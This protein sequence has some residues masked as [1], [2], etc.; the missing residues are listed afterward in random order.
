MRYI[1]LI[2]LFVSTTIFSI[3]KKA[4]NIIMFKI[5]TS[6][7]FSKDSSKILTTSLESNL[8]E[9]GYGIISNKIQNEALK[10]Q[11][12]QHK[13]DCYDDECLV[14]TG[15]MLAAKKILIIN[16]DKYKNSYFIK[17]KKIDIETA[18]LENTNA[19]SYK[20]TF[21]DYEKV[22][23]MLSKLLN[24][25]FIKKEIIV[26]REK[27]SLY[28]TTE[29]IKD[30]KVEVNNKI[31]GYTPL[32]VSVPDGNYHFKISK[33]NYNLLE[34]DKKIYTDTK[35]K[36][37]LIP[38]KYKFTILTNPKGATVY[39]CYFDRYSKQIR[40]EQKVLGKTPYTTTIDVK[41]RCF[42]FYKF[43]YLLENK[44]IKYE[45]R[46]KVVFNLRK[47]KTYKISFDIGSGYRIEY[48]D[49]SNIYNNR[50]MLGKRNMNIPEGSYNFRFSKTNY[51]TVRQHLVVKSDMK[52]IKVESF[53][54]TLYIGTFEVLTEF[55]KIIGLEDSKNY[56]SF[57]G[58]FNFLTFVS[59]DIK[60]DMFKFG[61]L[62]SFTNDYKTIRLSFINVEVV[63]DNSNLYF[64]INLVSFMGEL[65][66]VV[67]EDNAAWSPLGLKIGY[68][69]DFGKYISLKLYSKLDWMVMTKDKISNNGYRISSGISFEYKFGDTTAVR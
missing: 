15:K 54:E 58:A 41:D 50:W 34:F 23:S 28:I 37:K 26:K 25:M 4:D 49:S 6:F 3:P 57:G 20:G 60:M 13:N 55:S 7:N 38:K 48:K 22:N 31:L 21:S 64:S 52:N 10:E 66:F 39:P 40:G 63:P 36:E 56:A 1:L 2:L 51:R 32:S 42:Q 59:D 45:N 27:N 53:K 65:D 68:K 24:K 11:K 47:K 35:I 14:D 30:A 61:Y 18:I 67:I 5:L 12:E 33:K 62:Q 17:I 29:P 69:I 19:I 43:G 8:T 9:L 46:D 16:I 44:Y